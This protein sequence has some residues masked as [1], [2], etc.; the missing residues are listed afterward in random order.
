MTGSRS[1]YSRK[2]R[3]DVLTFINRQKGKLVFNTSAETKREI[4]AT[5]VKNATIL[6]LHDAP[7]SRI[8]LFFNRLGKLCDDD[9][10]SSLAPP[11]YVR[12][13]G[14]CQGPNLDSIIGSDP[15]GVYCAGVNS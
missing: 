4:V 15:P 11:E 9:V 2:D 1:L 5:Y 8:A 3:L 10:S 14:D 13:T 12:L 7:I 6:F